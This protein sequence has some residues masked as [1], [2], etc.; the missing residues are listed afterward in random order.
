MN[1]RYLI[2][3]F[4]GDSNNRLWIASCFDC[5]DDAVDALRHISRLNPDREFKIVEVQS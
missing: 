3:R 2:V 1:K 4:E 5:I